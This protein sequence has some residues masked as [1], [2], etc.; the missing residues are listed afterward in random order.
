MIPVEGLQ[1]KSVPP[2]TDRRQSRRYTPIMNSPRRSQVFGPF[3]IDLFK[4]SHPQ[5]HSVA[6][7]QSR[8]R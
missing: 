7:R 8:L 5:S 1:D 6:F 4:M 3:G 2:N